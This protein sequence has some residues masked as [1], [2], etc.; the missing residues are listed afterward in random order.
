MTRPVGACN[1][2][3]RYRS[4]IETAAIDHI[5]SRRGIV[6]VS[7]GVACAIDEDGPPGDWSQ[8]ITRVDQ[9]L[10]RAKEAGRK[11]IEL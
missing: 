10:Y 5:G 9:A 11:R 7:C 3:E 8:V 2:A 4:L 6:T 1:A